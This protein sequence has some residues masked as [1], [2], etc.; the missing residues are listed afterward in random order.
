MVKIIFL[1]HL[2]LLCVSSSLLDLSLRTVSRLRVYFLRRLFVI[3]LMENGLLVSLRLR[4]KLPFI[5][6]RS[7][8][9]GPTRRKCFVFY[10][11]IYLVCVLQ[12]ELWRRMI[13]KIKHNFGNGHGRENRKI[14]TNEADDFMILFDKIIHLL[15]CGASICSTS[16][17]FMALWLWNF[18][19]LVLSIVAFSLWNFLNSFHKLSSVKADDEQMTN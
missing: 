4:T 16:L 7:S 10:S 5:F 19:N 6:S 14:K 18:W 3:A 1:S 13:I 2:H 8:M 17:L 12:N 15:F 11:N 9:Q